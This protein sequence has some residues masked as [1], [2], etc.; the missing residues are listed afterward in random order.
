MSVSWVAATIRGRALTRRLVGPDGAHHLATG[1]W[2]DA[3]VILLGSFYGTDLPADADRL[4]ASRHAV[5][6]TMWQLRV[7]AGWLPPGQ[8][9]L[10]RIFAGPM[11]I[12]NIEGHL[13]HLAGF[14]ADPPFRLGSLAVAWPRVAAANSVEQVRHALAASVWR[15]PGGAEPTS[16]ALSLRVGWARRLARHVPD[17]SAWAKGAVAVLVARERF[18]FSRA[19]SDPT[20]RVVDE[21]IGHHYRE[22][23]DLSSFVDRLP[24]PAA[25]PFLETHD[26]DDLWRAEI[27]VGRRVSRDAY[28]FANS[29]R[30]DKT[31]VTGAM[32]LLLLDLWRVLGAIQLAGRTPIPEEFFDAAA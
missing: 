30:Y 24:K 27:A 22:A 1:S 5:E 17:T 8:S 25:W 15:E 13:A 10:A 32:A 14:E 6:A 3:R 7:L 16:M 11:E 20:G 9:V 23:Y 28:R 2:P 18:G 29:G 31:A 4:M 19:V 12:A 21:L 26:P